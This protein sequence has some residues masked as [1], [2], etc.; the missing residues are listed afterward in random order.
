[1]TDKD[2]VALGIVAAAL[3][4]AG[5]IVLSDGKGDDVGTKT[6]DDIVYSDQ[7]V[8][9]KSVTIKQLADASDAGLVGTNVYKKLDDKGNAVYVTINTVNGVDVA[10]YLTES[11]C[12]WRVKDGDD[13]GMM[14]GSDIGTQTVMRAGYWKGK[15]CVRRSCTEIFG[16]PEK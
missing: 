11:P 8:D 2:K 10:T 14:D 3:V 6:I 16:V 7:P 9:S 15:D 12:A 1:M 5:A 4:V 13:C